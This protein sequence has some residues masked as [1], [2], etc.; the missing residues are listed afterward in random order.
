MHS[1]LLYTIGS[2]AFNKVILNVYTNIYYFLIYITASIHLCP[3]TMY[4]ENLYQYIP[5]VIR[6]G[7][8]YY[9]W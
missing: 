3:E 2:N 5:D 4:Q 7:Q 1:F 9:R 6:S 8:H